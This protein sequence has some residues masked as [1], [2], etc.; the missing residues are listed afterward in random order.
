MPGHVFISYSRKDRSY[1][2]DLKSRLHQEGISF[3]VDDDLEY[4]D[5]WASTVQRQIDQAAVLVVIVTPAALDSEWVDREL[6]YAQELGVPVL[7]LLR[8]RVTSLRLA[9]LQFED[10]TDG[11][12]PSPGF[13]GR[14]HGLVTAVPGDTGARP[15]PY[16]ASTPARR[17]GPRRFVGPVDRTPTQLWSC[18]T[19]LIATA[20]LGLPAFLS[21]RPDTPFLMVFGL[22]Y[23][24]LCWARRRRFTKAGS[25]VADVTMT[26]IL[27]AVT[28]YLSGSAVDLMSGE[29]DPWVLAP[30]PAA[31]L[32][33]WFAVA[34]WAAQAFRDR[35][36]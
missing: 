29:S 35:P 7:P 8:R 23:L 11:R 26:V 14:L 34:A 16:T 28:F 18:R 19:P 21:E 2:A 36:R 13:F 12:M 4:G 25:W 33:C 22:V 27:A 24:P 31:V 3:W 5:R 15:A 20:L 1:V 9:N 6:S 10:V 30:T 17:R 32:L